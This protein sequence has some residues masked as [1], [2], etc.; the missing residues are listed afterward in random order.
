MENQVPTFRQM[1]FNDLAFK[2]LLNLTFGPLFFW[3]AIFFIE[4]MFRL[5]V[6]GM[7]FPLSIIGLL[8][9]IYRYNSVRATFRDGITIKGKMLFR[10]NIVTE[11]S[12]NSSSVTKRAYFITVGY[13]VQGVDYKERI[14]LPGA[15]YFYGINHEG[16]EFDLVLKETSPRNVL[17]KHIYLDYD[18]TIPEK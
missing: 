17:I 5:I 14:R 13:N 1:Y 3:A 18:P 15:P 4:P 10:E 11:R 12:K 6:T 7:T 2:S 16:Q 8:G 9:S